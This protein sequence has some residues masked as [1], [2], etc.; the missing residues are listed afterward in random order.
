MRA[1]LWRRE[2]MDEVTYPYP[3]A[4]DAEAYES[5]NRCTD[6]ERRAEAFI[7]SI[8]PWK[9]KAVLD[10]G[11][12]SGF[13]SAWFAQEA[14]HVIALEPDPRLRRQM[15]A[16]LAG[17]ADRKI[18]VLAAGAESIPLPDSYV[19]MGYARFAYFFGTPDCLRGLGEMRRV[20]RPGGR[21]FVVDVIPEWGDGGRIAMK[22]YPTVF[23]PKYHA[24]QTEFYLAQGF[25]MHRVETVFR[26]PDKEVMAAV[27]RM[28]F[29]HAWEELLQEAGSLELSYGIAVFHWQKLDGEPT[30]NGCAI[31]AD[32]SS[33]V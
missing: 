30:H 8:A 12:G 20:L 27:F 24:D 33:D 1:V 32:V 15:F 3:G 14:G 21:F 23:H 2:T 22:A 25:S 9:G 13:H 18:S 26:A 4:N 29:P 6:P 17:L 31:A 11:A 7:A 16:R 5:L 10:V 19:D 28:D